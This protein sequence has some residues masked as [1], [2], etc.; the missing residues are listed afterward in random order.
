MYTRDA[1]STR[2]GAE[3]LPQEIID[4]GL[5]RFVTRS[6][7]VDTKTVKTSL[8][9]T[10]EQWEW[11]IK[12][13]G[14][15]SLRVFMNHA[16]QADNRDII[17]LL[18]ENGCPWDA[19]ACALAAECGHLDV[20]KWLRENGCPCDDIDACTAAAMAGH[21]DVLKWLLAKGYTWCKSDC[22]GLCHEDVY[23]WIKDLPE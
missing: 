15:C 17:Q 22:L 4:T 6:C 11:A 21:L 3:A 8:F 12:N 23:E 10:R 5:A 1:P 18:R 13:K 2:R 20:L 14:S 19:R 9:T 16:I 7:T